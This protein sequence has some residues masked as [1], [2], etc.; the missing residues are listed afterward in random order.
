MEFVHYHPNT[1][2]DMNKAPKD[3]AN[4]YAHDRLHIEGNVVPPAWLSTN[5]GKTDDKRWNSSVKSR[6]RGGPPPNKNWHLGGRQVALN[7][8]YN[9]D[10]RRAASARRPSTSRAAPSWPSPPTSASSGTE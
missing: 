6:T 7:E 8:A 10:P 2:S 4:I 3:V 1:P 9:W 5:N